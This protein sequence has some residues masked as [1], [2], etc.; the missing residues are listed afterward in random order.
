MDNTRIIIVYYLTSIFINAF[1]VSCSKS[2]NKQVEQVQQGDKI[3]SSQQT[4]KAKLDTTIQL[5]SNEIIQRG[6]KLED[7][8]D[9]FGDDLV[10]LTSIDNDHN[11]WIVR[12]SPILESY[13]PDYASAFTGWYL[14][15]EIDKHRK[16][17]EYYLSNAQK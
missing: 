16:V 12:F 14:K 2:E 3:Y 9:I 15:L 4:P 1:V 17:V 5:M 11:L 6:T 7:L 13:K 10:W 8:K